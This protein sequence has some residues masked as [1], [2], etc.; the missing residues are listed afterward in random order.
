MTN[1]EEMYCCPTVN[2]GCIYD[3]DRGDRKTKI[4]KGT[5]FEELPEDWRCP[6][7]GAGKKFFKPMMTPGANAQGEP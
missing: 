4:P 7:C 1:P 3:P 6:I 2:C 5:K